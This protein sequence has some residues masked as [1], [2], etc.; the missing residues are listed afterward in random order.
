L[1]CGLPLLSKF[2]VTRACKTDQS[3]NLASGA[4]T[5]SLL[6][7]YSLTRSNGGLAQPWGQPAKYAARQ[8]W[9]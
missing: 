4:I 3:I 9:R 1:V 2:N 5:S 8:A 7:D 6:R